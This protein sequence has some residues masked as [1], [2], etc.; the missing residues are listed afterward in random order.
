MKK[1][2]YTLAA[3]LA[4]CS[5]DRIIDPADPDTPDNPEKETPDAVV[6]TKQSADPYYYS[7]NLPFQVNFKLA[8]EGYQVF[9][10]GVY[11]SAE[12]QVPTSSDMVVSLEPDADGKYDMSGE[13]NLVAADLECG[14][15]YYYRAYAIFDREE[16]FGEVCSVTTKAIN[17]STEKEVDLGLSIKWAGWNVG[18]NAPEEYGDY[19]AW[20]E[21]APQEDGV[22]SS[23][24]C[25]YSS[26]SL[27]FKYSTDPKT[28]S[29]V[30][31]TDGRRKLMAEDD[32]AY[33]N[34]GE[35]WRTPTVGEKR[36]LLQSTEQIPFVYKGVKGYAFISIK[37]GAAI[38]FPATGFMLNSSLQEE[39]DLTNVW[40]SELRESDNTQAHVLCDKIAGNTL[41]HNA[42]FGMDATGADSF[43]LSQYRYYGIPVRAVR[44][45]IAAEPVIVTTLPVENAGTTTTVSFTVDGAS[46]V[47]EQGVLYTPSSAPCVFGLA[48]VAAST[49]YSATLTNLYSGYPYRAAGYVI[50]NGVTY[51]GNE[52]S[53]TPKGADYNGH[54]YV[55]LG[56]PSGL[57]WASMNVG[58]STPEGYGG[59]FAWGETS[60]KQYYS[61]EPEN[62]KFC[63]SV[64]EVTKY[65]TNA[66][67]CD[68]VDNLT[69]LESCD[70]AASINWGGSWRMPLKEEYDELISKCTWKNVTRGTV[71]GAEATGPN[72]NTIFFPFAGNKSDKHYQDDVEGWYWT[73][74]LDTAYNY[75]ALVFNLNDYYRE[76]NSMSRFIGFTVRAV[77][78]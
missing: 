26:S 61:N 8:P 19:F 55:D 73:S 78:E 4:I 49:N 68:K 16:F 7:I 50:V 39:G 67:D 70:D 15:K 9:A 40:T 11:V 44:G 23:R 71:K 48:D 20:G 38:F 64:Y 35:G 22:Y 51:Y 66:C 36:E 10:A 77:S 25:K 31:K 63:L 5:C 17:I 59:F 42:G 74:S 43:N 6:V 27:V 76:V 21:T 69:V 45:T 13:Y 30:G 47:S 34:W 1:I 18:A 62:Y 37:N 72:G 12:N 65:A 33:V 46:A 24:S 57:K 3:I 28:V 32:A 52:V 2:F 53:F 75:A 60:E 29:S 58:A 14:T 56:L 41:L 54:E